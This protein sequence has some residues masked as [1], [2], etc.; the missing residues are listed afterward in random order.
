MRVHFIRHVEHFCG[1]ISAKRVVPHIN[2]K[3]WVIGNNIASWHHSVNIEF[4]HFPGCN[5]NCKNWLG[6]TPLC[7]AASSGKCNLIQHLISLGEFLMCRS[8]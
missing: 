8:S 2:V 1:F 7:I 3:Y 4:V 6:N 5:I